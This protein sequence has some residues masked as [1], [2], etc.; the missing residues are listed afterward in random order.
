MK[1]IDI[2]IPGDKLREVR[3]AIKKSGAGGFLVV[4]G[5]GQGKGDR[6]SV[7][8]GRG[9]ARYVA[10]YNSIESVM[11]IVDD[12]KANAVV[13]AVLEA[14]S[15]GSKGDGKIFVTTVDDAFDIGSKQK[16]VSAI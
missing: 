8:G 15:T 7:G 3:D 1:R 2:L 10:E 6:P 16:G 9:T 11:T 4:S 12:S 13:N 14:T 5:K